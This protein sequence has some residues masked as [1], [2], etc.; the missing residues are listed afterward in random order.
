MK[1]LDIP[2]LALLS[3]ALSYSSPECKVHTRFEA[4]TCKEVKKERK[5]RRELEEVW[6][7]EVGEVDE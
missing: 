7:G 3:S 5:L 4:Y 1:Y 2:S 6:K